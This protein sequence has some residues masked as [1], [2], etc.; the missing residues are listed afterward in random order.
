MPPSA[1]CN[2]MR[3]IRRPMCMS[4]SI[5]PSANSSTTASAASAAMSLA[6]PNAT[7]TVA[8]SIAAVD[9]DQTF[10][11]LRQGRQ[12]KLLRSDF[13]AA[14][15]LNLLAFDDAEKPLSGALADVSHGQ[16]RE[17]LLFCGGH[18]GRSQGVL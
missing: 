11:A 13:A 5:F 6:E 16:Q 1:L 9:E 15:D 12:R 18:D 17:V 3:R 4:S 8:A 14:S 10:Q 2:A 7:P